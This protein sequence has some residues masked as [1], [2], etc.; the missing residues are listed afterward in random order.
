MTT[1]WPTLARTTLISA[2]LA[3]TACGGGNEPAAPSLQ[4]PPAQAAAPRPTMQASSNGP[5]ISGNVAT[6]VYVF[7]ALYGQAPSYPQILTYTTQAATNGP[8]FAASL[9]S[10]YAQTSDANLALLLLNN[11]GITASTVTAV[12][13]QGQSEY[14]ILLDALKQLLAYYGP[15][16]RGQIIYNSVNLLAGLETDATY[17]GAS[18]TF[19]N[20]ALANYGYSTNATSTNPA[21]VPVATANAGSS[22]SVLT[23][24]SVML[25]ASASSAAPG[26]ALSYSWT[27]TT[28]PTGSSAVLTNASTA[29]ASLLPDVVGTYVANLTV[30]DGTV[31]SSPVSVR[32]ASAYV[33][34]T[35]VNA[36]QCYASGSDTLASCNSAGAVALNSAQDGM[37]GP[38][39]SSASASDGKLGF[40]FA[41]VG[42]YASTECIKDNLTGLYWEGKPTSGVRAYTNTYSNAADNSAGDASSYVTAVNASALCGF[43]DWRL[44]TRDELQ[45][46]VDYALVSPTATLDATWFPNTMIGWYWSATPYLGGSA[47]A[48]YV[49]FANGFVGSSARSGKQ[50]LRLVR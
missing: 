49:S 22:R 15:A 29:S 36:N 31:T 14:A 18:I 9:V 13:A 3:L 24:A 47:K 28:K 21:T 33:A 4:T 23:N 44:P 32:L 7:Q 20:Q 19:N 30:N 38:D 25:D 8:A 2:T 41:A 11:L 50:A 10:S 40:S 27:L 37:M 6:A 35:G 12:N 5:R 39:V 45:G 46:L 42:S 43:S 16:W 26:K 17:G 34:D 1:A 48:W